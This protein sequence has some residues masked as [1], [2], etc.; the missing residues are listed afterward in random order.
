MI[1]FPSLTFRSELDPATR[2]ELELFYGAGGAGMLQV[3]VDGKFIGQRELL[4]GLGYRVRTLHG[5]ATDI[6]RERPA[7][8]GEVD[9]LRALG[10]VGGFLVLRGLGLACGHLRFLTVVGCF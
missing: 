10:L 1:D 6:V 2:K 7:L 9:L 4:P 8:A 5:L 3:W